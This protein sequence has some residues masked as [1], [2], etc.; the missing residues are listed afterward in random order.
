M[1][2][3]QDT[4]SSTLFLSRLPVSGLLAV[5]R[6]DAL[7]EFQETAHTFPLAGAVIGLLPAALVYA[8]GL[9][10]LSGT[11]LAWIAIATLVITTG[12]LHEDGLG[13]V[14]DGFWGGH[15]RERKLDIMR[16]SAIGTYGVL[17]LIVSIGGKATALGAVLNNVTPALGAALILMACALSRTAMLYPW[18]SLPNARDA[19][20]DTTDAAGKTKA[21][22]SSRFGEPDFHTYLRGCLWCLPFLAL[23]WAT[24]GI[25]ALVLGLGLVKVA[26]LLATRLAR[27]HIQGHT[28]DVLGATQ[29]LAELAFWLGLAIAFS[30]AG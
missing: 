25:A 3:W 7:P 21:G 24:C 26:T 1:R 6:R 14:V 20:D 5:E 2:L 17:A 27:H 10:G 16:D 30:I 8:G 23:L 9:L 28:G 13:D 4:I 11:L 18:Y 29:Q 12:A 22:L 15:E 19:L